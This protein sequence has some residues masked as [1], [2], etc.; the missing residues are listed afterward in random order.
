M[1]FNLKVGIKHLNPTLFHVHNLVSRAPYFTW[2]GNTPLKHN[3]SDVLVRSCQI[4]SRAIEGVKA[5][6]NLAPSSEFKGDEVAV[7][8]TPAPLSFF[9]STQL[10]SFL[11]RIEGEGE[12]AAIRA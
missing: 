10:N 8:E 6:G 7:N 12:Q 2:G 9:P 5:V 11:T 3:P 1:K 4:R